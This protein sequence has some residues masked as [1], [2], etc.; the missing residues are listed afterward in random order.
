MK[1]MKKTVLTVLCLVA[2]LFGA[3]AQDIDD[4]AQYHLNIARDLWYNSANAAGLA[5][6]D[7]AMWRNVW[8]GYDL[9]SGKFTD[10][11]GART[12]SSLSLAGDMLMDIDGYKIAAKVGLGN[13]HLTK[14]RYNTSLYEVSWD[15]P[16]FVALNSDEPFVWNQLHTS[17]DVSASTPLFLDDMLSVGVNLKLDILGA[18][19]KEEPNCRYRGLAM[20]LLPSATFAI[21]EDNIVG[22]SVGYKMKPSRSAVGT[23]ETVSN[24]VFLKG[25]G[26]LDYR[27]AGGNLGIAPIEYSS[28]AFAVA[29][30]YKRVA[31]VSDWLF[32]LTFDKCKTTVFE[33]EKRVGAV[34][35]FL[36]GLSAKGLFGESRSRILSF[37]VLHNLNYWIEGALATTKSINNQFDANLDYT[38]YTGV[39]ESGSFDWTFGLGTDVRVLNYKR[40]VPDG[41]FSVVNILPYAFLGK[42]LVLTKE[43]SLLARFNMGYN[44]S[45]GS[46]YEYSGDA[47]GNRIVGYM[48]DD[49]IDY[50]GSYYLRTTLDVDYTY[51]LN[52]IL[53]PYAS[54][55]IG[56]LTPMSSGAGSRFIMSL[57]VGVLF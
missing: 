20:E 32:E 33:D 44:F 28:G 14:C 56:L 54:L 27:L 10:A 26:S 42:N 7:M 9:A 30:D 13:R 29:L 39:D 37:S 41:R 51:R 43:Q 53:A 5:Y 55:G 49:E 57:K 48:Y 16:Y 23:G 46:K 38:V 36:T 8:L 12:Q 50:L 47:A 3:K 4:R 31:D 40:Y 11:W 34:D 19:K 25:L 45:A 18:T 21:D 35:K 52:T 1:A 17:L 15:M 24:V 22:L 6:S 2:F